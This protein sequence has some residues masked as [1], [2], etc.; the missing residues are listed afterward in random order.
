MINTTALRGAAFSSDN[1]G[2]NQARPMTFEIVHHVPGRLRL[3]SAAMKGNALTSENVRQQL[4]EIE[5]V[6]SV[7]AN[8]HT[9]SFLLKYHPPVVPRG[10]V[11]EVL[12]SRGFIAQ[13]AEEGTASAS[14]LRDELLDALKSW[15]AKALAERLA[16]AVI[17]VLAEVILSA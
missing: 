2:R 8:P 5:G 10:N 6:I 4:A 9:G 12:A 1:I 16:L 14:G 3:R 15:V 13:P 7:A 17:G 11:A